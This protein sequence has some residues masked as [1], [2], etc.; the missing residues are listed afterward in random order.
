MDEEMAFGEQSLFSPQLFGIFY[1]F[2]VGN[3]A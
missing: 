1:I 3:F 2:T